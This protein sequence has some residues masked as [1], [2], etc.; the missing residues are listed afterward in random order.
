LK[1]LG[2]QRAQGFYLARPMPAADLDRLIAE[3]HH[4]VVG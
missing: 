4:W 2:C 3:Q 1:K